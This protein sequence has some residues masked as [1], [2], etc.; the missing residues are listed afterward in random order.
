MARLAGGLLA[1][2]SVFP[3]T[4]PDDLGY[5]LSFVFYGIATIIGSITAYYQGDEQSTNRL[6]FLLLLLIVCLSCM[7]GS[8]GLIFDTL[9]S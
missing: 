9:I 6:S 1:I 7:V 4:Y 3:F 5:P 2:G 8:F